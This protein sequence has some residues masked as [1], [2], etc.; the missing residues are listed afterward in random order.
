MKRDDLWI[1]V[2]LAI[3]FLWSLMPLQGFDIWFY[4][5]YGRQVVD[6]HTIPWSESFLGSTQSLA[7]GRHANHAWLSYSVC[8]LFYKFGGIS[9]LVFLRSLLIASTAAVTYANCRQFGLE[10]SWSAVLVVL[11]V[12]TIRG[13]FLLRSV[14]FT[15]LLMAILLDFNLIIDS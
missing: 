15:D 13:R 2:G 7:F 6:G 5:E 1:A 9:A 10:K 14:L 12:W 4:L 3:L 11:G 8:Y